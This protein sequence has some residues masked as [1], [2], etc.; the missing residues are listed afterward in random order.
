MYRDRRFNRTGAFGLMIALVLCTAPGA[1]RAGLSLP[2][3]APQVLESVS[4]DADA[5][6]ALAQGMR[7]RAKVYEELAANAIKTR[8]R[9]K[10]G[11]ASWDVWNETHRRY[12][13]E[14]QRLE[15]MA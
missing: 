4:R 13:E 11:S 3:P 9:Q 10:V 7:R 2:L 14:Q 8:D 15:K 5:D 12:W 1:P 6:W